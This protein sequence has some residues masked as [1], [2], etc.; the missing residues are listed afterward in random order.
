MVMSIQANFSSDV[1]EICAGETVEFYDE[2]S[3]SVTSWD[4]TFE[5]GTPATSTFQ[6]PTVAY[7]DPGTYDVTLEVSDGTETASITLEN[8]ITVLDV[9]GQ[10]ATPEGEVDICTNST[11][12]SEYTTTGA[13][14][15]TSYAWEISPAE[16]GTI[17]GEDMTGTVEW[18]EN[19]EG[20]AY[21]TVKG[22]NDCGE[23]GFSAQTEVVCS[24]CTGIDEVASIDGV[25]IYPNPSTGQFNIK[26][27]QNIG[28]TEV[29]V[30]N[31]LSDVVYSAKTETSNG[32]TLEIDLQDYA[33]G[34]YFVKL[35]N[36]TTE[37]IQKIVIR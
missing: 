29:Q 19:W 20:T 16:A 10:A 17:S 27:S 18:T 1:T 4:W 12:S 37:S 26:F 5:G 23:G 2:S 11:V 25:K 24:I 31:L 35:K 8:Y 7:F 22:M 34:V 3:N 32:N 28:V 36:N 6:N 33:D 21:I 15:A 14:G 30:V 13:T 9:P